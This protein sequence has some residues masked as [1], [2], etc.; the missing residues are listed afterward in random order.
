MTAAESLLWSRRLDGRTAGGTNPRVPPAEKPSNPKEGR[1]VTKAQE[2]YERVEALVASGVKKA[3]AFRQ[4]AE[5]Y[6]REFNSIRGAYYAHTRSLGGSPKR[7]S[8][9]SAAVDPIE[10]AAIVLEK[11]IAAID[12]EI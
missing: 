1:A 9:R 11:A 8:K 12:A 6:G 5:E 10:S 7:S 4:V 2:V 3:D